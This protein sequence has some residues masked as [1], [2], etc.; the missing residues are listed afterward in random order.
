MFEFDEFE[1]G[2]PVEQP[3]THAVIAIDRQIVEL[4]DNERELR[5]G[6]FPMR[7]NLG[8]V[9]VFVLVQIDER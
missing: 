2:L 3:H 5:D 9:R 8:N 7:Q 4:V 6:C 1:K